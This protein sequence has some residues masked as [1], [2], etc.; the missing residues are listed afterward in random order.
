MSP[1]VFHPPATWHAGQRLS[2]EPE[3]SHYLT[4]VRRVV[5]GAPVEVL[6]GHGEHWDATLVE[7][8]GRAAVV[9]LLSARA[10]VPVMPLALVLIVPEPRATL[11]ALTHA[12]E[13]GAT[14]VDLVAGD[15]SPGG[16]P[17]QARIHR[18]LRAAQRQCGRPMAPDVRG[19]V[20]LAEAIEER[21]PGGFVASVQAR[22]ET[23][24]IV[25]DSERGAWLLVG[26]EGGLSEAERDHATAAGLQPVGLAPWILRTPTA[27]AAGLARLWGAV[28]EPSARP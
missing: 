24:P 20:S 6:D 8:T 1:R 11:E 9:E 13:L 26:P 23:T 2:L 28:G 5:V 3:E 7:T 22:N 16:L 25:V 4:R 18:T 27:V 10:V 17:S 15:H 12:S 14:A 21:G 19:P